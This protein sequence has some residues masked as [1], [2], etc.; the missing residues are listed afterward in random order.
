MGE[1]KL[2]FKLAMAPVLWG[3]AL[4]AGRVISAQLPP[5][6]TAFVRFL[7]A[8][9]F[10]MPVLHKR[11]GSF[12]RPARQETVMILLLSITGVVCFNFF[13]FSGLQTVEAGRSAVIIALTPAVVVLLSRFAVQE[14][15]GV[16][17][18]LGV[19]AAI[20]GALVTITDGNIAVIVSR[21]PDPGDLW[22]LAAVFS[23]ALYT[24]IGKRAMGRLSALTVL[25]YSFLAGTVMLFPFALSEGALHR[26]PGLPLSS[27][28][29]MLYL[30]FGSAGIAYL[31]YYE[32]I[33]HAGPSRASVFMNLEPAAAVIFGALLLGESITGSLVIGTVLV[34][35]G[36]YLAVKKPDPW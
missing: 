26:V 27:W 10:M 7:L 6:T 33:R 22:I 18:I 36:V 35:G 23:W 9:M 13:L 8:G 25:T 1:A 28:I 19:T 4:V 24:L 20:A 21:A 17:V 16:R 2:Y 29:S 31:W 32:G 5:F 34:L 30:S 3:G 14:S 12:P 15:L 11:E